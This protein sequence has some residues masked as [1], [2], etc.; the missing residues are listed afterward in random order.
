MAPSNSIADYYRRRAAEARASAERASVDRLRA[1]YIELAR[2]Y[3]E[4]ASANSTA[5][6]SVL[7]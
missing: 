2:L 1:D 4:R 7:P 6:P 5:G 3:D